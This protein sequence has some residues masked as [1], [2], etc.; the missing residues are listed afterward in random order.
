MGF[1]YNNNEDETKLETVT[2]SS[3]VVASKEVVEN[4]SFTTMDVEFESTTSLK[5]ATARCRSCAVWARTS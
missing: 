2:C 5:I 3:M 4:K 1:E